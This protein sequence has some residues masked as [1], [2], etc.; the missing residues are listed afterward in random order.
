MGL[1]ISCELNANA[2]NYS[3]VQLMIVVAKP[4]ACLRFNSLH[5]ELRAKTSSVGIKIDLSFL[6]PAHRN[7]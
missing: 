2:S 6:I 5:H 4:G 7:Q 3:G 1:S